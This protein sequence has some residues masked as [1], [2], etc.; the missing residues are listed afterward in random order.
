MKDDQSAWWSVQSRLQKML[1]KSAMK[2]YE[3]GRLSREDMH[4]YFL[5]GRLNDFSVVKQKQLTA[6]LYS[7]F[8]YLLCILTNCAQFHTQIIVGNT[9]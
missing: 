6:L 2:L 8:Y 4:N 5:S 9:C 7:M 3:N 1:R